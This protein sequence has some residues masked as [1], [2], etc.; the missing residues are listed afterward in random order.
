[1]AEIAAVLVAA[2]D[3][4]A[5]IAG[6]VEALRI[7]FRT[8]KVIVAD[9]SFA[10]RFVYLQRRS[11]FGQWVT[12]AKLK[13]GPLSGRIFSINRRHGTGFDVYRVYITVNQAGA[14]YL[15]GASGTQKIR[16]RS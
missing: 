9:H 16:R 4:E 14:G 6:T 8:A 3:E 11:R 1:M 10:G 15:D 13:L 5:V 12:V 2:R 7:A